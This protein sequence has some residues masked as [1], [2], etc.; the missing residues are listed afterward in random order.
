[1]G[2]GKCNIC[3]A[4]MIAVTYPKKVM[5]SGANGMPVRVWRRL[6]HCSASSSHTFK[7]DDPMLKELDFD[8]IKLMQNK[9]NEE[10]SV[11]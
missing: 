4:K 5:F 6:I 7:E 3:N 8:V 1:M 11:N 10:V 9:T 2:L